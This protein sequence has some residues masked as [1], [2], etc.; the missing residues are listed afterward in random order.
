MTAKSGATASG[1]DGLKGG[2]HAFASAPVGT[3]NGEVFVDGVLTLNAPT[4]TPSGEYTATLTF[5]I[6]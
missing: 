3:S 5:T 4:S 2:P 6:A 1:S